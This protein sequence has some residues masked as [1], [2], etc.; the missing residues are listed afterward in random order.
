MKFVP[1][2][3]AQSYEAV[4]SL[5][6][7]LV[8]KRIRDEIEDTV[9]LLEHS[10][11]ITRGRGL[12]WTG[13][14]DRPKQMPTPPSVPGIEFSE[15]ERGGDLTYHGPGQLVI[16]PILKM[17]NLDVS[18]FI[19]RFE[20]VLI[21]LLADVGIEAFSKKGAA[22]VWIGEKKIASVGIAVKQLVTYHGMAVNVVNDLRPFHLFS[23]CGFNP[24]VM[25]KLEDYFVDAPWGNGSWRKWLEER[26][27]ERF[28]LEF[29]TSRPSSLSRPHSASQRTRSLY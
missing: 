13:E 11:V 18:R 12:Q 27:Q 9:L 29:A 22:G 17:E 16:Y 19:R 7:D 20:G 10:P 25:T 5:Q 2:G 21:C 28:L 24:E 15:T 14:G 8:E 4:R 3:G 23:P 1:L 6:K 26:V